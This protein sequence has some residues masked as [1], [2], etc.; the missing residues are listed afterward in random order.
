MHRAATRRPRHRLACM[1]AAGVLLAAGLTATMT[2]SADAS[3]I[4]AFIGLPS[5]AIVWSQ[6]QPYTWTSATVNL[7]W[8]RDG[9]LVLYCNSDTSDPNKVLWATGTDYVNPVD[10]VFGGPYGLIAVRDDWDT[11][12]NAGW[13][14]AFEAPAGGVNPGDYAYVQND[15]NFVIYAAN[16]RA[17]WATGTNGKC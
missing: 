2:T 5:P 7:R 17:L 10:I 8:Q 13:Q 11:V 16:G 12:I 9:N 6:S 14:I 15:G 4:G 3:S 1:A